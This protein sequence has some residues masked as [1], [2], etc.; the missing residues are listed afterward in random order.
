MPA[1]V[2]FSA[3]IASFPEDGS[4]IHELPRRA[5]QA[6]YQSKRGGRDMVTLYHDN[7]AAAL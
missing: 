1:H 2:T 4:D 3:G 7:M 5:D 6:M